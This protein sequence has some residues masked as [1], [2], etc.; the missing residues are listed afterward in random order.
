MT[1]TNLLGYHFKRTV[2]IWQYQWNRQVIDRQKPD[3]V[4]DEILERFLNDLDTRKL[5]QDDGLS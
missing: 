2:Y 5:M 3:V 1:L 4:V